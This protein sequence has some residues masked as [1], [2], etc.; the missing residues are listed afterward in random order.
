MN[1]IQRH[2]YFMFILIKNND[3]ERKRERKLKQ[4]K[5]TKALREVVVSQLLRQM[6][7]L[8]AHLRYGVCFIRCSSGQFWMTDMRKRTFIFFFF[9]LFLIIFF[10]FYSLRKNVII[11]IISFVVF[12]KSFHGERDFKLDLDYPY[13]TCPMRRL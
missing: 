10:P 6:P 11:I 9:S 1:V 13:Y 5:C 7:L 2:T 12:L 3:R 4:C 8:D